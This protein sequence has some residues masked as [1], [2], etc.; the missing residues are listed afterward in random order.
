MEAASEEIFQDGNTAFK[1]TKRAF[2]ARSELN[3]TL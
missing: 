3:F 1:I 2:I